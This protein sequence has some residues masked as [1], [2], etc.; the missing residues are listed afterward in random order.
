MSVELWWLDADKGNP[1]TS[2]NTLSHCQFQIANLAY[3]GMESNQGLRDEMS[4]TNHLNHGTDL[5]EMKFIRIKTLV[6]GFDHSV[7]VGIAN[8]FWLDGPGIESSW[9]RDFPSPF[10]P[11]VGSTQPLIQWVPG[12]ARGYNGRDVALTTHPHPAPMLRMEL[13]LCSLSGPSWPITG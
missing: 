7:V 2:K 6:L 4:T 3:P 8:S 9:G 10:R 11:A 5:S 12:L 1:K 13:S